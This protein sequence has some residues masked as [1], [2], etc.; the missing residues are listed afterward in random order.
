MIIVPLVTRDRS[1]GVLTFV[2]AESRR[3]YNRADLALAEEIARRAAAAVENARLYTESKS[4]QQAL[5]RSN[6]E[7]K[8]ANEDLNQFAYSASHDLR[9]PLRMVSI[10]SQLLA[11][12][13]RSRLDNEALEYIHYVVQGAHRMEQLV[14]DLLDTRA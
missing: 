1:F 13:Y 4:A 11:D 5:S 6:A 14:S 3:N 9:E 12:R 8:R 7:L 2:S 10:Y